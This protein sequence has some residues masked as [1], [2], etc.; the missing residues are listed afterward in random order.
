MVLNIFIRITIICILQFTIISCSLIQNQKS[1]RNK[2][3]NLVI[4]K[5]RYHKF[6][7]LEI[8]DKESTFNL[9]Y[10]I[11]Y[12]NMV[13]TGGEEPIF[14]A[15]KRN[16]LNGKI[17]YLIS[18]SNVDSVCYLNYCFEKKGELI[19]FNLDDRRLLQT[20]DSFCKS[21]Y[22]FYNFDIHCLKAWYAP[23]K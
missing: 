22:S 16:L 4:N 17:L 12:E 2:I 13:F 10:P 7:Y 18:S 21:N 5:Y 20:V 19:E 15:R 1:K 23:A 6:H 11:G 9:I 3:E 14:N 8:K